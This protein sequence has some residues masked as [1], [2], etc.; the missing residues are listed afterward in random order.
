MPFPTSATLGLQ[1]KIPAA[2]YAAR[3]DAA[4]KRAGC[5]WLVV[6]A[7]REHFGNIAF[8]T[9]FEPRFEEALLLLGPNGKRVLLTGNESES[10]A[11][12]AGLPD[13]DGSCRPVAQPDGAR[14]AA[15]Y[16]RLADRLRDAGLKTATA[17]VSSAGNISSRSRTTSRKRHSSCRPPMCR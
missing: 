15:V 4:Y 11:P 12:I 6:Y 14:I 1:P 5:D 3:A 8:L 2:T 17:S 16:P 7:D 9:G 13:I 10:Y